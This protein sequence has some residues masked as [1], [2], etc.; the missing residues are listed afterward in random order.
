M[1]FYSLIVLAILSVIILF[2]TDNEDWFIGIV[3]G[4]LGSFIVLMATPIYESSRT[5]LSRDIF[6]LKTSSELHGNFFLGS[7]QVNSTNYYYYY[8]KDSRGGYIINN[9]SIKN[10]YLFESDTEKPH[11]SWQRIHY[12]VNPWLLPFCP[13]PD[14]DTSYDLTVP[15]GTIVKEYHAF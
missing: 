11:I 2:Y 14:E 10:T 7:G 12:A 4:M 3:S 15:V 6:T 13:K 8:V 1:L 5:N 9:S